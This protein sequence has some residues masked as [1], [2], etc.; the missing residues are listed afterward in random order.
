MTAFIKK[1]QIE[2]ANCLLVLFWNLVAESQT[3]ENSVRVRQ[4]IEV[5]HVHDYIGQLVDKTLFVRFLQHQRNIVARSGTHIRFDASE[6]LSYK[7]NRK[8]IYKNTKKINSQKNNHNR[9]LTK[10]IEYL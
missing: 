2:R 7:R 1:R 8:N 4:W 5:H 3:E 6:F 9:K 10:K